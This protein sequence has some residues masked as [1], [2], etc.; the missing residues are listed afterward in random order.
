MANLARVLLLGIGFVLFGASPSVALLAATSCD[1]NHPDNVALGLPLGIADVT[2]VNN[3]ANNVKTDDA[4]VCMDV[5]SITGFTLAQWEQEVANTGAHELGHL[6]GLR[7]SDDPEMDSLMDGP[8]NGV[9]KI[10]GG[11]AF[12]HLDNLAAET[13]VVWL[14]FEA[15]SAELPNGIYGPARNTPVLI[16]MTPAQQNLAIGIISATLQGKYSTGTTGGYANGFKLSFVL[17]QPTAG[18]YSTVSFVSYIPE[19]TTAVL[20]G[21]GLLGLRSIALRSSARRRV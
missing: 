18:S 15:A 3:R 12:N 4:L 20:I 1:P 14:D 10:F 21:F 5:H 16:N 13:Q 2:D 19:P 6:F 17:S 9:S 7:H 8:Y 11:P